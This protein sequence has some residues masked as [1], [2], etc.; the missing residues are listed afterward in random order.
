MA[1]RHSV[2]GDSRVQGPR[3]MSSAY[4][5]I[6][7]HVQAR[8]AELGVSDAAFAKAVGASTAEVRAVDSN[9]LIAPPELLTAFV[10]WAAVA[11]GTSGTTNPGMSEAA[12]GYATAHAS[13]DIRRFAEAQQLAAY[14]SA[15][16]DDHWRRL[17]IDLAACMAET[18]PAGRPASD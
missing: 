2:C 14:F 11:N 9:E 4:Q 8:R 18:R 13:P 16:A 10:R 7:S 3:V 15:I 17:L 1:R 5:R 6:I 12:A